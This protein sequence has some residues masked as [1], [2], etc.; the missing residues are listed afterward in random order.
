MDTNVVCKAE[1]KYFD[2]SKYEFIFCPV[3][4]TPK[5]I[6]YPYNY[7]CVRVSKH[8]NMTYL[9]SVTTHSS[10]EWDEPLGIADDKIK[11]GSCTS[12][13]QWKAT[14]MRSQHIAALSFVALWKGAGTPAGGFPVHACQ[15]TWINLHDWQDYRRSIRY[16]YEVSV[17]TW[18]AQRDFLVL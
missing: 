3:I 1:R 6:H 17:L 14:A 9:K 15:F 11:S 8:V 18:A 12:T 4:S 2:N 5:H 10:S 13:S 7:F 16:R